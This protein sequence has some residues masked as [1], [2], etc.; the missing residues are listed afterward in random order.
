[1][2][3]TLN[4]EYFHRH[5]FVA[6]LMFAMS[7]WFAY[8]GFIGYPRTSA[9]DLYVS[10]EK[11][12]PEELV[13]SLEA[14]TMTPEKLESFKAQKIETQYGLSAIALLVSLIVGFNLSRSVKF[15]LEYDADLNMT[16]N[17]K[18]YTK[19]DIAEVDRKA[20][21]KKKIA[22]LIMK[23]GE[24]YA[25]DAWHHNGVIELETRI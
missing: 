17:G 24:K 4:K 5:L 12:K 10:I 6:V 18:R 3:L 20:W 19:D 22:V 1:M 8:D 7:A 13:K 15:R 14:G 25:L 9:G 16:I 2:K 11:V 21:Q 23:S